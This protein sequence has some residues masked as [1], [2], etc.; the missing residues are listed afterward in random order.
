MHEIVYMILAFTAGCALGALFFGGLWFT[1]IKMKT[2]KT[3]SL[4]FLA[5]FVF[6]MG[7]VLLGFYFIAANNWQNMLICLF[8]FIVARFAIVHLTKTRPATYTIK[9]NEL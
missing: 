8:G 6:R 5:S 1:I 2:T 9:N 7:A 4:F 3:P